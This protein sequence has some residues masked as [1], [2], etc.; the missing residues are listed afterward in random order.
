MIVQAQ[1][2]AAPTPASTTSP[3]SLGSQVSFGAFASG[4]TGSGTQVAQLEQQLGG[5]LAIASSFRGM[6]DVFP[7]GEQRADA[8][9][10]H[11]LLISWDMGAT[12]SSRFTTF[13]NGSHDAYLRSEAVAARDFGKPMYIRPWAEMNGDWT[14]FQPTADGSRP[15]GGTPAEFVAAWQHVVGVFRSAGAT[16]VKWVFNPTADTYAG[17]TDVRT[18]FPGASYVDVLGLDGYNWGTGGIFSWR[19]FSDIY[20]SQYQRLVALAP[21]VPVWVCEFAS[22]EPLEL[23][24]APVDRT[25][26]KATWYDEAFRSTA[27]PAVRA[28]VLFDTH[29]ERDWRVGSNAASLQ[30][31]STAVRSA[32][33]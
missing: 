33:H 4:F 24:G 14:T 5:S 29:K 17:T 32:Q 2:S 25:H 10:G 20:A 15:A 3:T 8:A 26:S 19:S 27:F 16:N 13:T 11:T 12:A 6:G 23:D 7:A 18:I 28:L 31:V 30:V 22:K 1:P 9:S 21:G